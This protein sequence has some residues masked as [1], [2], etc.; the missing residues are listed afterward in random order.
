MGQ[1]ETI[2]N[3]D[4]SSLNCSTSDSFSRSARSNKEFKGVISQRIEN[5]HK[6]LGLDRQTQE[7]RQVQWRQEINEQRLADMYGWQLYAWRWLQRKA[8]SCI[9]PNIQEQG[10]QQAS[11]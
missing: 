6:L 3:S 11:E 10:R 7:Q 2:K 1:L 9:R 4:A 8:L 5:I